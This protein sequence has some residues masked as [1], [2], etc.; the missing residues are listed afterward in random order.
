MRWLRS[1]S[2]DTIF[3]VAVGIC[4]IEQS[5]EEKC[6]RY[7]KRLVDTFLVTEHM[8]N[9]EKP[10]KKTIHTVT[11]FIQVEFHIEARCALLNPY[12]KI[13]NSQQVGYFWDKI[14][15]FF[16]RC[17]AV[18]VCV[19]LLTETQSAGNLH[20]GMAHAYTPKKAQRNCTLKQ[21]NVHIRLRRRQQQ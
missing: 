18:F 19:C 4:C 8:G 6:N 12:E 5:N 1:L 9:K 20:K 13:P 17:S 21:C 2:D 3:V 10:Q 15:L 16:D 7:L 11:Q 14:R